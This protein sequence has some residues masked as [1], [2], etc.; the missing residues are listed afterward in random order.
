MDNHIQKTIFFVIAT[1]ERIN[2][3]L[4]TSIFKELKAEGH[5][6][7]IISPFGENAEFQKEF[8]GKNVYFEPLA[9]ISEREKHLSNWRDKALYI[10]HPRLKA[11]RAIHELGTKRYVPQK[12]AFTE[13][14][15]IIRKI[16]FAI[17]PSVL[18]TS[19]KVWGAIEHIFGQNTAAKRLFK[20]YRPQLVVMA[21]AGAEGQDIALINA[22]RRW[23]AKTIVTDSN[24]DVF[25]FRYFSYPRPVNLWTLFSDI[26]RKDASTIQRVPEKNIAITGP[27]RYDF[28]FK[29][30]IPESR[31]AFCKRLGLDPAKKIVIYGS[32]IKKMYP[33]NGEIIDILKKAVEHSAYP[34]QLYVRFAPGDNPMEYPE[35]IKGIHYERAE[36]A[37]SRDHIANLLYHSDVVI[38]IGSTFCCEAILFNRPSIWVAFDGYTVKPITDSYRVF[39]DLELF[40]RFERIGGIPLVNSPEELVAKVYDYLKNPKLD[41]EKRRAT[42]KE[43]YGVTDGEAGNRVIA[44]IK[45]L[46]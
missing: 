7:V 1:R 11:S 32:K 37:M 26:Q 25:E 38:S 27:V 14:K 13:F 44:E 19:P 5:S 35:M 33:P 23:G 18:R 34:S 20:R 41:E 6:L 9:V 30:F 12:T 8:A 39:Y 40:K 22:A 15:K 3:I 36:E 2:F 43:Q 46:L 16:F 31:E 17:L 29:E 45:K 21:S 28:Y 10:D 24:I 4:R 42:I